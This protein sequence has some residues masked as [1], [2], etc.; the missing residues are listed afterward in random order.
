MPIFRVLKSQ[1]SKEAHVVVLLDIALLPIVH[2]HAIG[3]DGRASAAAIP[4]KVL[5]AG[6]E[7]AA[8]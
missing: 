7:P 3:A 1:E 8:E 2:D 6:L 5:G 4:L